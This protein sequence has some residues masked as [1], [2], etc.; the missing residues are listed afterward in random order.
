[1]PVDPTTLTDEDLNELAAAIAYERAR[2]M[3]PPLVP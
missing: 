3:S 1:M 2:R